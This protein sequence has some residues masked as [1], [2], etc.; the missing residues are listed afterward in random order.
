MNDSQNSMKSVATENAPLT[1]ASYAAWIGWDWSDKTH[2]IF[3]ETPE[4]KTEQLQLLNEPAKL[5]AWLKGLGERFQKRKMA[6]CIEASRSALLPIFMQYPFLE[7]YLVNPKSLAFFREALRPSGS[8][9]DQLD[10]RLACQLVKSHAPLLKAFQPE[11]PLTLELAQMVSFRRDLVN[12]RT[13]LAN[14]LGSLLKSY[15]PL[16]LELLCRDTT[17]EMAADFV[18]KYPTLRALQEAPLYR[19]RQ[20]FKGHGCRLTEGLE[21]RLSRID[22]AV[23]VSTDIHWVN[24]NSFMA[25]AVAEQIKVL[26]ARIEQMEERIRILADQHPNK[27]LVQSAPGAGAVLEPR[28]MVALGT[29]AENSPSAEALATRCGIAPVR[30]QSGSSCLVRCRYAKPQFEHQT[31]I[32][33]AKQSVFTCE[34]AK[35]FVEAKVKDGKSYFT[36]IRA[37]AYKWIRILHACWRNN[38]VYDEAKYL[39]SLKRH[40]SPY[41]IEGGAA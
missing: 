24:P 7:L 22:K 33:F 4:G 19:V 3:L 11:D 41:A 2:D 32:E 37:L 1:S 34:W 26:A 25:C 12:E 29:Q 23:P 15:Y 6:L 36:A 21:E 17:T 8:K 14:R 20:F 38:E 35:K 10:C 40:A 18:L 30:V 28:L 5:H 9:S 39:L 13:A 27:S 31:W 16:A